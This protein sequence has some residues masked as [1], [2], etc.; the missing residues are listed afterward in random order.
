[1]WAARP[2]ALPVN[3]KN[4]RPKLIGKA[5]FDQLIASVF[6]KPLMSDSQERRCSRGGGYRIRAK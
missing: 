5:A 2:H 4:L 6:L 3:P 1:M